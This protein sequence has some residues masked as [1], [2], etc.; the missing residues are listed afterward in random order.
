MKLVIILH[1]TLTYLL[2]KVLRIF[3]N[4]EMMEAISPKESSSCVSHLPVYIVTVANMCLLEKRGCAM[5]Q[6]IP[7]WQ[8]S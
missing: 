2:D 3:Y 1:S 7:G 8:Q 4:G 6:F 5:H